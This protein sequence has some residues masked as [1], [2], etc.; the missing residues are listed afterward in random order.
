[1]VFE[2]NNGWTVSSSRYEK[3]KITIPHDAMIEEERNPENPSGSAGAFFLGDDYIYENEFYVPE[4]W[5][6]QIVTFEFEGVY[7]KAE[8][9]LNGMYAGKCSYGY[10]TFW[11]DTA[12]MLKYGEENH[13]QVKVHNS[14]QPNSRWYSGSGIYRPVWLWVQNEKR[15]FPEGVKVTTLSYEPAEIRV[16]TAR[17]GG[18]FSVQILKNNE[19]VAAAE[20]EDVRIH[21]P[22]V[23][24]WCAESPN[25]YTCRVQLKDQNQILEQ[26]DVKFGIRKVEWSPKGLFINGKETL[27]RG[28]CIHHDHGILGARSYEKSEKRRIRILK[29]NGYN[30]VRSSHNPASKSLVRAC[31][32]LGMYVID[33]TWDMWYH[34]KNKEDYASEFHENYKQ[35]IEAMV[36][37]DYNH[38]S[39]LFYSIGNEVSEPAQEE[40]I[41]MEQ[42]MTDFLH[43]LDST[44]AVTCGFNLMI[45]SMAANGNGIYKEEGGRDET[46]AGAPEINSSAMFNA[47]TAQVGSGMNMAANSKEADKATA[48]GLDILDIAGYNY[49]SGRYS[50]EGE[51]H[52]ERVIYGSET[53]PQDIAKNWEMVKK[54]PYLI[55]DFMWTAWDYIGEAGIG[56]WAYTDDGMRFDKP[57]PW[58]L[59]EVGAFDILGNENA[60]A[61]Y[62]KIVWD[63]QKEPYLA[64]QPVNHPGIEPAKAVW[65]GTNAIPSWSWNGCD[66]NKAVVEVYAKADHIKLFLNEKEIGEEKTS[67]YKA[68]F[69]TVYEPGCLEAVSYDCDGKELARTRLSS[70]SRDIRISV[71]P[72]EMQ[73]SADEIVYVPVTLS[74]ENGTVECNADITLSVYVRGGELL[75]FGSANPRTEE[76]YDTGE[77][78]TYYGRAMAVVRCTTKGVLHIIAKDQEGRTGEAQ[79]QVC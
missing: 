34:H 10:R 73:V 32:E 9:Y 55:G 57:Y 14:K 26:R 74:D 60:E 65:R 62:V 50:L 8:V 42:E 64:V 52:P 23:D 20:G 71:K 1:M 17:S 15:I 69:E 43:E 48:R 4:M 24:L 13:I 39:V 76:R 38:P 58:L 51:V 28:G 5:K 54:Y 37:Q 18:N 21:I 49:A 61:G 7:Q 70:A 45:V 56:A 27:L 6:E 77:F 79:I 35:D 66:G 29:G 68:M 30:A 59:A 36:K 31:D 41:Q 12:G 25:L 33:E 63:I 2:F 72:E 53:F 40:G 16:E 75:A 11:I 46:N 47:M 78:A 67:E 44:R 19:I 22:E 3:E